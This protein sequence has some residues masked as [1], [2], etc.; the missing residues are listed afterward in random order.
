MLN[1][2][3][4][5][6]LSLNSWL[7]KSQV[8]FV[9]LEGNLRSRLTSVGY[10]YTVSRVSQEPQ[11]GYGKTIKVQ[12]GTDTIRALARALFSSYTHQDLQDQGRRYSHIHSLSMLPLIV[13]IC[14]HTVEHEG[15]DLSMSAY[16]CVPKTMY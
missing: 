7:A 4:S 8:L 11:T 2:S 3:I 9:I 13:I 14:G 10:V 16:N 1:T 6:C 12:H 15:W 5:L